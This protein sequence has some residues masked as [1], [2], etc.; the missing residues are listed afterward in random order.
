[1]SAGGSKLV[2]GVCV[3]VLAL[4]A[5]D[6]CWLS[7]SDLPCPRGVDDAF[8]KSPAAELVQ[9]GRLTHPAVTGYLP[10]CNEVFAAYPPFYQLAVA[11]WFALF[12]ISAGAS[13]S[14]GHAVH[15]ANMAAIMALVAAL[16]KP[17]DLS[18]GWRAF[19]AATAGILFFGMLR[20]FDRQEE[21][22]VFWC[23]L[24]LILYAWGLR[25]WRG[26]IVS[27]AL[28]GLCGMVSPWTGFVFAII[29]VIRA[30][31]EMMR[32][33]EPFEVAEAHVVGRLVTTFVVAA[34]PVAGWLI[35]LERDHP[36]II[37]EQ[38]AYH[39]RVS[40]QTTIFAAPARA[41][42]TLLYSPYQLPALLLTIAFFPRLLA[43]AT[44][45]SLP[46]AVLAL[47]FGA[48]LGLVIALV[49][50]VNSYNYVW[51]CLILLM[52]CFGYVA[53]RLLAE[54]QPRER[55]MPALIVILCTVTSLRDPV[56]LSL[57]ARDLPNSERAT[58]IY[59]RLGEHV[60]PGELVAT[61]SRYWYFF[62]DHDRNPWR[63]T[64]IWPHLTDQQRH[65]WQWIVIPVE[66]GSPEERAR[67]LEGFEL[68][69]SVPSNYQTLAPSFELEDRTW[70]YELY[71]RRPDARP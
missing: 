10:R 39:L 37:T 53:S 22:A 12:G 70:A 64:A 5:L 14:F 24:D 67:F 43:G 56:S 7:W 65:E 57:V 69:D 59:A 16:V 13:A 6:A 3:G 49:F 33:R 17:E 66:H 25:G 4:A 40:E 29:I 61:T 1:M 26:A 18:A 51:A 23:F 2:F 62:Q 47:F 68:V 44:K 27:G 8:Y 31:I 32:R 58:A 42:V 35:W 9:H 50:R 30:V 48:G 38:F 71:R 45:S 34:L 15:L 41:V 54:A 11:G 46:T 36:G 52:P 60:P 19:V 55:F 28:L 20:F 21:L 63:L